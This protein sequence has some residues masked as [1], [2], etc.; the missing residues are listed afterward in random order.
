MCCHG[1]LFHVVSGVPV[2]ESVALTSPVSDSAVTV[3]VLDSVTVAASPMTDSTVAVS[4]VSDSV[5]LSSQLPHLSWR[6]RCLI[7]VPLSLL[8]QIQLSYRHR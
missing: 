8:C 4:V 2:S 6:H 7:Q 5:K 1:W 3:S